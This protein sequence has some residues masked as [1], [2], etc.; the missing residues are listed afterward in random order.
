MGL[1][2]HIFT[3]FRSTAREAEEAVF[4]AN[5]VKILEQNVVDAK[6]ELSNS[7]EQRVKLL[8]KK[9]V[10]QE[11]VTELSQQITSYEKKAVEMAEKQNM[12]LARK[13]VEK[14]M[15]LKT[16]LA[17]HQAS[18]DAYTNGE[19][20]IAEKI[21][22]AER[23]IGALEQQI[24]MVKASE[25][26]IKAQKAASVAVTSGDS[27]LKTAAD[28]LEAIKKKQALEQASIDAAEQIHAESTGA[29]LDAALASA[30]SSSSVD[31]ELNRLLAQ[32]NKPA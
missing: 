6:T 8:A 19:A 4:D 31:D 22:K 32:A 17:T 20:K 29:D 12:D 24:E 15:E 23:Q 3:L 5:R 14:S 30:S 13:A 28:H 16:Q 21:T 25:S 9:K 1:F 26:V 2:N 10:E 18:L 7:K 27:S 11:L